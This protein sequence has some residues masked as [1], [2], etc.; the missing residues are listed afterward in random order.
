MEST[1]SQQVYKIVKAIPKGKVMTYGQIA[2]LLG[3][4]RASRQVGWALHSVP[5]EYQVPCQRVVN[6]YGGLAAG[7][8][9]GGQLAHRAELEADG[10]EI[11]EDFTVDLEKYQWHPTEAEIVL[12]QLPLESLERLNQK[13]AFSNERLSQPRRKNSKN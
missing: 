8:G 13:L 2:L 1:F 12:L 9:W 7:Y 11:R 5:E 6:R 3:V 4:P 10:V